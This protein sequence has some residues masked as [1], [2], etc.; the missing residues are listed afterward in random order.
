MEELKDDSILFI[1][2]FVALD[3][4]AALVARLYREMKKHYDVTE[5]EIKEAVKAAYAEAEK[6]KADIRER[7]RKPSDT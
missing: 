5:H 7:V 1:R 4:E 3:N 2:P 6:V